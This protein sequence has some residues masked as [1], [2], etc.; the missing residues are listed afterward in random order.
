MTRLHWII[1][2]YLLVLAIACDFIY[3]LIKSAP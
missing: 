1:I 3:G 2:G